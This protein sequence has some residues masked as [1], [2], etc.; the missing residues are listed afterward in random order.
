MKIP[1]FFKLWPPKT[2]T[3]NTLEAYQQMEISSSLIMNKKLLSS[4]MPSPTDWAQV[5]F[6][7]SIITSPLFSRVRTCPH[8]LLSS[9]LREIESVIKDLP[10]SH[11]P[12]PDGFDGLF[13]KKCWHIIKEDFLR[14]LNSFNSSAIDIS[15]LNSSYTALIPKRSNPTDVGDYRPISLLNY[16]LKCLTKL[17]SNRLQTTITKVVHPNQYGFIKGRTPRLSCLGFSVPPCLSPIQKIN[18]YPET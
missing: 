16:S 12:G 17:L 14:Y 2:T 7:V 5:S 18:Y 8:S 6:M 15:S 9:P 1:P 11:A 4:G 3:E 10:N 13:I